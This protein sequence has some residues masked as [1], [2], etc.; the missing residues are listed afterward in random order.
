VFD[1]T[2]E[3]GTE[4]YRVR[5]A[6]WSTRDRP[7]FLPKSS[8]RP[9]LLTDVVDNGSA[10][11]AHRDITALKMSINQ[12][13]P[14]LLETLNAIATTDSLHAAATTLVHHSTLQKRL[15]QVCKAL[16]WDVTTPSGKLR[17]QVAL[18]LRRLMES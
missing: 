17:L 11:N 18:L 3:R 8:G 15:T 4:T 14:W 13:P 10:P 5:S 16:G 7:W 9:I 2:V 6:N 1:G 12:G